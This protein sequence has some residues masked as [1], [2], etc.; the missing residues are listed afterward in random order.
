MFLKYVFESALA[1][2]YGP[3]RRMVLVATAEVLPLQKNFDCLRRL[4]GGSI[5]KAESP[6]G[7]F[8]GQTTAAF[9]S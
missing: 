7:H 6:A 1:P 4:M 5:P 3:N 2:S 8:A 9:V